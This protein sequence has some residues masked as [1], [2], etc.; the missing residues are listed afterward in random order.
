MAS[1][2]ATSPGMQILKV[3]EFGAP[4]CA[5]CRALAPIVEALVREYAGRVELVH[6]DCDREPETA[7]RFDVRA[8]PTI[9]LLRDG[10]EVGRVIGL[11]K[12]EFLQGVL[13]RALR[14]DVAIAGP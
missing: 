5:P 7:A 9:V 13:D 6:V 3:M 11:R 14:G 2:V 12:R 10:R 1:P 4:H 8:T